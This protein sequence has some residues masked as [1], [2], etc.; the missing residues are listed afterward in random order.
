MANGEISPADLYTGVALACMCVSAGGP[1]EE[2]QV[3]LEDHIV[4]SQAMAA[5]P[6]SKPFEDRLVPWEQR[7]QRFQVCT[8]LAD[9]WQ[10]AVAAAATML[11]FA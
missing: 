3:L 8:T 11:C 4:K 6:F 10:D 2:A 5:S 1:V 9:L 7:L